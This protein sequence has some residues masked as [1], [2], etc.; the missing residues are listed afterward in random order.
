MSLRVSNQTFLEM[1]RAEAVLQDFPGKI[2]VDD[3]P[4]ASP[5]AILPGDGSLILRKKPI[6]SLVDNED[7]LRQ[8][9]RNLIRWAQE[10]ILAASSLR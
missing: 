1:A 3:S 10:Q 8:V 7:G 6:Q 2:I 9:V 5:N 4:E